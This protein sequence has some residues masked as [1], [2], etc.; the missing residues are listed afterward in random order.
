MVLLAFEQ[1]KNPTLF[2]VQSKRQRPLCHA[3]FGGVCDMVAALSRA[4]LVTVTEHTSI[5]NWSAVTH[6]PFGVLYAAIFT[7]ELHASCSFNSNSKTF[8]KR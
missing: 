6:A 1:T 5:D 3:P 2:A 4:T 7:L 8:E